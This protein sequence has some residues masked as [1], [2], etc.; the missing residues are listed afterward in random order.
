MYFHRYGRGDIE[1]D[2]KCGKAECSVT[3][4]ATNDAIS[5]M[6]VYVLRRLGRKHRL[7]STNRAERSQSMAHI[8]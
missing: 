5:A 4:I 2:A 6:W 3:L 1:Y 7:F 8:P